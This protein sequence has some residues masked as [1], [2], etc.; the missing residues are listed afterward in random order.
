M[1]HQCVVKIVETND[2]VAS[3]PEADQALSVS[4]GSG[5]RA[6]PGCVSSKHRSSS[7]I[8]RRY[9]IG[10]EGICHLDNWAN[11]HKAAYAGFDLQT[12]S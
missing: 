12:D 3:G 2:D 9:S 4:C 10:R 7:A 6:Y 1:A 8:S 11:A 5:A